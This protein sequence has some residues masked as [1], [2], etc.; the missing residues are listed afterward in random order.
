MKK[1]LLASAARVFLRRNTN[2]LMRRG[3]HLY[4]ATS[5]ADS[6][7]LHEEHGFDL[8]LADFKLDDMCGCTLCAI[9]RKDVKY[10]PVP[11]VL[12]CHN[13]EGSIE[14]V[15]ESGADAM[16]LK[17]IDPLLL[18]ETVGGF[19][20][21]SLDRSKRVRLRVD[22]MSRDQNLEFTCYSHDISNTGI[23]LETD[24][25]LAM[26]SRIACRFTLPRSCG[27]ET[28]GEII[29]SMSGRECENLYGVKFIGLPTPFRRA[30]DDFVASAETLGESVP[31]AES[32]PLP[33]DQGFLPQT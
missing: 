23:L 3:F 29:R 14:R 8:I 17:P 22:V 13:I 2:L 11:V 27:I 9:L 28:G 5:G 12:T 32:S 4:T 24:H 7:K 21:F 31:P 33:P 15:K 1:M 20:G 6:L 18:L 19:I 16:L 25:Q 10:R 26:G 30:I